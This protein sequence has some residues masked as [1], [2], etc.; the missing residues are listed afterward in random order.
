[1]RQVSGSVYLEKHEVGD[2]SSNLSNYGQWPLS[3]KQKWKI[4]HNKLITICLRDEFKKRIWPFILQERQ[5]E[6]K[7]WAT[8][9]Y[10]S[11][12]LNVTSTQS[13]KVLN[14]ETTH[15][16]VLKFWQYT[17]FIT[18]YYTRK[19]GSDYQSL[20]RFILVLYFPCFP[21][22]QIFSNYIPFRWLDT[23]IYTWVRFVFGC[24]IYGSPTIV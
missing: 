23:T 18:K 4:N 8:S 13:V 7:I 21:Q 16:L 22:L 11:E 19:L 14:Q 17:W 9:Q 20:K 12:P 15:S 24:L 3:V 2:R 1:M 5:R 6:N 10:W